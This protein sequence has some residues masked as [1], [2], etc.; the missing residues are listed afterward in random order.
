M[1]YIKSIYSGTIISEDRK[2]LDGKEIDILIPDKKLAIEYN[3]L[4]WHSYGKSIH[5]KFNNLEHEDKN[6]HLNKTVDCESKGCNL[7]HIYEDEWRLDKDKKNIWKSIIST[8][9]GLNTKIFARKCKI[10]EISTETA[11]IFCNEN[12]IQGFVNS[13]VKIGLFYGTELV[14]LMMFSKPR[15]TDKYRWEMTRTCSKKFTSVIGG[16]KKLLSHFIKTHSNSIISYANRNYSNG[17]VYEKSN[18]LKLKDSPPNYKYFRINEYIFIS[19]LE[20]QKHKL[21]NKLEN[22]NE[23]LTEKQNMIENGY[24]ILWDS[25]NLVY[26]YRGEI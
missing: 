23:K 4:I 15:F 24:R 20:S 6:R 5:G 9:L 12:H 13:S 1:S 8:K 19:R 7:L 2:L 16:F 25:G 17:N 21:K 26:T 14:M 18:F 11:R 10:K 22:F 3:G